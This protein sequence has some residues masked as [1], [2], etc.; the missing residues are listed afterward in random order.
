VPH[1]KGSGVPGRRQVCPRRFVGGVRS[2]AL[3][4]GDAL[5]DYL[6]IPNSYFLMCYVQVYGEEDWSFN[7]CENRVSSLGSAAT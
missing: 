2:V 4:P 6:L 3:K 5:P 1:A 7:F